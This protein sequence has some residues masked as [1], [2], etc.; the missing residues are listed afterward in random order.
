M[1]GLLVAV[2]GCYCCCYCCTKDKILIIIP[3]YVGGSTWDD[4][5][6]GIDGWVAR[7]QHQQSWRYPMDGGRSA[8]ISYYPILECC[9][10]K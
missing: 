6:S 1:G 8:H 10:I 9:L 4:T 3:I 7:V 5:F 2:G